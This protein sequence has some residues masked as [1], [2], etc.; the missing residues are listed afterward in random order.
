MEA[1]QEFRKRMAA[2]GYDVALGDL[3]ALNEVPSQR[4][5]ERRASHDATCWTS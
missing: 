4:P 2:A 1:G 3:W 5:A